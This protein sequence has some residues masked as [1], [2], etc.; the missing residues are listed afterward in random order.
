MNYSTRWVTLNLSDDSLLF[1]SSAGRLT[2]RIVFLKDEDGEKS[3]E[4]HQ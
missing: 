1:S 3:I 2:D 4:Y